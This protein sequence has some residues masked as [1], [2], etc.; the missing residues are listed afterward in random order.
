MLLDSRL[1]ER[2]SESAPDPN[3][4]W[5]L[6]SAVAAYYDDM[7]YRAVIVDF[8]DNGIEVSVILS[9]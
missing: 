6:G 3:V 1:R 9:H 5:L 7:F 2:Y 4:T 8:D